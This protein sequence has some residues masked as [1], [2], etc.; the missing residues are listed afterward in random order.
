MKTVKVIQKVQL[1][2]LLMQA[3]KMGKHRKLYSGLLHLHASWSLYTPYP[4]VQ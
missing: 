4:L 3:F 1:L 2:L